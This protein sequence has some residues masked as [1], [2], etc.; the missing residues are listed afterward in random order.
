[1][2]KI[3]LVIILFV[4]ACEK[5][6]E[7][8]RLTNNAVILA[9]GD[10]LTYGT[11]ASLNKDYPS[12]LSNLSSLSVINKGVP[13]EISRDGLE[14]LPALLEKYQPELLLLIHGGNDML[15]KIP[16]QKTAENLNAMIT[17]AKQ[18]N[19]SV[20]MLGVPSPGLFFLDSAEIYSEIARK[21]QIPADLESLPDILGDNALK[22]DAIHP[23]DQGYQVLAENIFHLLKQS[24]AF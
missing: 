22:S 21:N 24:G 19:I 18:K 14:R 23:N 9:F 1:M 6:P 5:Q 10:S 12:I 2:K 16:K 4:T 3:L 8:P 11:G 7:L 13:G 20:I 15:R 17:V